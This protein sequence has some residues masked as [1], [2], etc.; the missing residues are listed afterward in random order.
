MSA[1][2]RQR[3][4]FNSARA[5]RGVMASGPA[6]QKNNAYGK[7]CDQLLHEYE[8]DCRNIPKNCALAWLIFSP[9][10][11]PLTTLFMGLTAKDGTA[12]HVIPLVIFQLLACA[13]IVG[14]IWAIYTTYCVWDNAKHPR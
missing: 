9:F 11:G 4:D 8:Q 10:L 6:A 2:N 1:G 13:I 3:Q 5:T 14:W 7:Y 12:K